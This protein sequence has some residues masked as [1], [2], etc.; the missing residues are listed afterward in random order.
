MLVVVA[1]VRKIIL[2]SFK[3]IQIYI[4]KDGSLTKKQ[5]TTEL[6]RCKSAR[7]G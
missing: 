6:Q 3:F 4:F 7:M 2:V 1:G 5:V